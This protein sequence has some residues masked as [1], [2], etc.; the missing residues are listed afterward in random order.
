MF[1]IL[2]CVMLFRLSLLAAEGSK[3]QMNDLQMISVYGLDSLRFK[4]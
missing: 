3:L 2:R 1:E 4:R